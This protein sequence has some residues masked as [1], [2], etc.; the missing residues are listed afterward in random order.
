MINV[1]WIGTGLMG[2]EMAAHLLRKPGVK[3]SVYN[4]TASKAEDLVRKGA[5][6]KPAK[7]IA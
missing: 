6:F 2:K 4:R 3:V 7:Q 1:G 5:V